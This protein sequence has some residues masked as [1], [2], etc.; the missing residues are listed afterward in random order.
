MIR[1]TVLEWRSLPYGEAEEAIPEA[2]GAEEELANLGIFVTPSDDGNGVT[3]AEVDPDSEASTRGLKAG[4]RITSVNNQA[5]K[6]GNDITDVVRKARQD[7]RSKA[8]FQV[9]NS[10]GSR[11]L[12]LPIDQ[13]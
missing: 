2:P 6:S 11:F 9:E 4:D 10:E 5:V 13:G 12:A 3:V 8:L 1:R 7:G